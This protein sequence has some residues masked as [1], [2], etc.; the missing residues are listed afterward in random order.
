MALLVVRIAAIHCFPRDI[1]ACSR[2]LHFLRLALLRSLIKIPEQRGCKIGKLRTI[3][4]A[5][6]EMLAFNKHAIAT[7]RKVD[8]VDDLFA[9][10]VRR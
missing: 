1:V 5:K 6:R 7:N 10:D 8:L 3:T 4:R 9:T 2:S